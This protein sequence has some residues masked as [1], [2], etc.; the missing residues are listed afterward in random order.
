MELYTMNTLYQESLEH[1]LELSGP[2]A[3]FFADYQVKKMVNL[4]K[5]ENNQLQRILDFGCGDGTMAYLLSSFL[6][7]AH[8]H[9]MDISTDLLEIAQGWYGTKNNKLTFNQTCTGEYDL[10]YMADVLHHIKKNERETLLKKLSEHLTPTGSLIILEFNPFNVAEVWRFYRN[11][12]EQGNRM[13]LPCSLKKLL[14]N[15]GT[16]KIYYY[17]KIYAAV[18]KKS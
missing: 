3:V 2:E 8:I 14:K 13:I 10:I 4:L 12:E 18:L 9:G 1:C 11:K 16:T 6:P 15:I 5:S 7:L 17:Q